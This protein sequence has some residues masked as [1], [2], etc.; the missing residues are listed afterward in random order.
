MSKSNLKVMFLLL[1][2][3]FI[4]I[5]G[6]QAQDQYSDV[7]LP[8]VIKAK[9]PENQRMLIFLLAG[10]S[11]MAGR[12]AYSQLSPVDTVTFS[13]ILS[14]NKDSVWIRAK[15]PLH[16]EKN[17]AAVGMGINFARTLLEKLGDENISIGLVSCAAGG[18]GLDKW[19]NNEWFVYTG[20]FCLYTNLI[21]RAKKAER[22]G[23]I[24]GLLWHQGEAEATS[25]SAYLAYQEKL[26]IFFSRVRIDLD[27]PYLPV[28]SVQYSGAKVIDLDPVDVSAGS[29]VS[30]IIVTSL[31]GVT[32][33]TYTVN[34]GVGNNVDYTNL[35]P[36]NDFNLDPDVN[37]NPVPIVAVMYGWS[38]NA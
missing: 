9:A 18:T 20:N 23:E 26:M 16:W 14:L 3:N 24:A 27:L 35:I 4:L 10:Q 22:S 38:D 21:S 5:A 37:C 34:Y 11:N 33:K 12:D 32:T 13:N 31:D 19:L 29:G 30:T 6:T 25:N 2:L 17:E 7:N 28:V 8:N 36:N 15:H 1:C